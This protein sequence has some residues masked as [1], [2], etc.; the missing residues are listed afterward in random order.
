M[1][2]RLEFYLSPDPSSIPEALKSSIDGFAFVR[3]RLTPLA[4]SDFD[5]CNIRLFMGKRAVC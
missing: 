1:R 2:G 4:W 3:A 5:V